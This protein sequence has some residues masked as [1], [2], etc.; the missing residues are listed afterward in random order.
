MPDVL[1]PV[2]L[3]KIHAAVLVDAGDGSKGVVRDVVVSKELAALGKA[4]L[5]HEAHAH[6]LGTGLAA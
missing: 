2:E 6:N 5:Y 1:F 4:F 3:L